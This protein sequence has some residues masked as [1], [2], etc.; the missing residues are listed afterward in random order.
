MTTTY[1][2][3]IPTLALA[4]VLAAC[5][6]GTSQ[7]SNT[8]APAG[9]G[10]RIVQPGAPGQAGRTFSADELEQVEG[11]SYTDADVRFMQGMIPHHRQALEM[12][13]LVRQ[14]AT[15]AAVRQMAL[16]MEISQRDEIAMMSTWLRERGE[17]VEMSV[18]G[19]AHHRMMGMLTPEQMETLA[20]ARGVEFDRLFLEGMI[21]HHEGALDMVTTLFNTSGA[22]QESTVFKFAEE[23]DADQLMEI[24][25]MQA[26]LEQI[27]R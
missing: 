14:H 25:R 21:Q 13:A 8:P 3:T 5:S 6:G 1:A 7:P 12:T 10:P 18:M 22:A 26:L 15:T 2:R 17:S 16:R 27:G 9:A 20:S 23:V 24:E 19:M 4:A 11:V